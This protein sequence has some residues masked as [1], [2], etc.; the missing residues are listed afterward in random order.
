MDN[1]Q[2]TTMILSFSL[3]T[4]GVPYRLIRSSS[5]QYP[6]GHD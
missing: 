1:G 2:M 3:P 4:G 5:Q 6:Y